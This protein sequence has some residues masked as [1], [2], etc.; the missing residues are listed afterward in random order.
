MVIRF[1][2]CI[3]T[4]ATLSQGIYKSEASVK[5]LSCV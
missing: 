3:E 2:D 1:C 5:A 4:L